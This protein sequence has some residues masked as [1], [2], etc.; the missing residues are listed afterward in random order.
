MHSITRRGHHNDIP[1]LR[2]DGSSMCSAMDGHIV[3]W[4]FGHTNGHEKSN[5]AEAI[6]TSKQQ[7]AIVPLWGKDPKPGDC[8][9]RWS[10][11]QTSLDET[12]ARLRA[13]ISSL[14]CSLPR[15]CSDLQNLYKSTSSISQPLSVEVRT[16]PAEFGTI[17]MRTATTR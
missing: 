16:S 6:S 12:I 2:V 17:L 7:R 5:A 14:V 3:L 11:G 9:L 1:M 4:S 8:P 10:M 13:A 15:K